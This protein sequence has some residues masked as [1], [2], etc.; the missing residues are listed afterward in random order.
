MQA[1]SGV[2]QVVGVIAF[3]VIGFFQ[4][5]A[6]VDGVEHWLGISGVLA[7]VA[8][9]FVTYIPLLG[10]VLGYLGATEVWHWPA[11]QAFGL[12]FWWI[13]LIMVV[14]AVGMIYEEK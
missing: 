5:F 3:V 2:V 12:F 7:W 4:W 6:I 13:P 8:A 10:S 1:I 14:W 9:G 11:W